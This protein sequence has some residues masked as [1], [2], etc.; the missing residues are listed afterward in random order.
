MPHRSSR[1]V[2]GET[3]PPFVRPYP[4]SW[5][6]RL[7]AWIDRVPGP[8]WGFYAT[9]GA[10]YTGLFLL[11]EARLGAYERGFN[12]AHVFYAILPAYTLAVIDHLD[13]VAA[14]CAVRYFASQP[15]PEAGSEE[16]L[17]RLTMMP[18][19]PALWVSL[20]TAALVLTL[21]I[22]G[23][24]DQVASIGFVSSPAGIALVTAHFVVMWL[25]YGAVV[26]H[27]IHQFRTIRRIYAAHPVTDVYAAA[28]SHG[29][30]GL[31]ARTA[32]LITLVN[33]GWVV[34][35]PQSLSNP[36]SLAITVF[37]AGLAIFIFVW[38]LWG[39]HQMLTT[40]KAQALLDNAQRF[41]SV[42]LEMH[43]RLDTNK[44]SGMDELNRALA[45]L[46]QERVRIVQVPTWP[47]NPGTFRGVIAALFTPIVIWLIQ[48][49]LGRAL[50]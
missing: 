30:S 42:A 7:T 2:G 18:P 13:R 36:L 4:P 47:W 16:M 38:P 35:D 33:Y 20:G 24:A 10:V 37:L 48:Y 25:L 17:F 21:L 23:G 31:T 45:S 22:S 3:P 19:G 39:A 5:I 41:K 43:R 8:T 26:Y 46:D 15:E 44:V 34:A 6:D 28:S 32:L 1:A 9:V 40:A 11:G 29:F 49:F 27:T 14:A 50:R 12:P